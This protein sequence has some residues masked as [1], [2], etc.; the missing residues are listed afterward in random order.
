MNILQPWNIVF[1]MGLIVY[2][3]IRH[4]FIQRTRHE[5]K[6][7]QRVDVLERILV[8]GVAFATLLLPVL[9]LFTP[10]LNFANYT[11]PPFLPWIGSLTLAASLLLFWRSH[12]ALG[13]NWSASLELRENHELITSGI[14]RLV[15]HP[16]YS[17]IWLW[18]LAQGIL[19]Q[20]W[21]A[22]WTAT[23]AF[24]AMYFLRIKREEQLMLERFGDAYREYMRRTGRVFPSMASLEKLKPS[25]T[26][27]Q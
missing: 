9:Y 2:I 25:N 5:R 20:N 10:L 12:A 6:E 13:Q 22:G 14:Y 16:M 27:T 26:T 4:V 11:L 1:F 24:A 17:S 23:L 19:L 7:I 21:L 18:A 15:R 3:W 8:I